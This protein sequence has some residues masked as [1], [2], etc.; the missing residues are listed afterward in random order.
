MCMLYTMDEI[1]ITV[2]SMQHLLLISTSQDFTLVFDL[3]GGRSLFYASVA[4]LNSG[5]LFKRVSF[6]YLYALLGTLV[7]AKA[8]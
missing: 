7:T 1:L 6:F 8:V 2:K 4:I 5:I 3:L